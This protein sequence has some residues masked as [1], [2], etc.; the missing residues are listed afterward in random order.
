MSTILSNLNS[1]SS[2]PRLLGLALYCCFPPFKVETDQWV[3]LVFPWLLIINHLSSLFMFCVLLLISDRHVPAAL[4]QK[5]PVF[6]AQMLVLIL[7][8]GAVCWLNPH[9]HTHTH[10]QTHVWHQRS[11]FLCRFG[12]FTWTFSYRFRPWNLYN[13]SDFLSLLDIFSWIWI[14]IN[15]QTNDFIPELQKNLIRTTWSDFSKSASHGW[16]EKKS[17]MNCLSLEDGLA[18][19]SF[20]VQQRWNLKCY[21]NDINSYKQHY[22]HSV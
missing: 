1:R 20:P 9:S 21:C 7:P 18:Y 11:G 10:I 2:G 3:E 4:T 22:V 6:L 16:R 15:W 17:K 5:G 14:G 13:V 19:T 8:L 12:Q